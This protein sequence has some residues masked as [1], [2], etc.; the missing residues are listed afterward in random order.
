MQGSSDEEFETDENYKISIPIP[1]LVYD[2]KTLF[3]TQN[4]QVIH[5]LPACRK[6]E[7]AECEELRH[8]EKLCHQIDINNLK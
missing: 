8:N 2:S 1:T 6:K 3:T 7:Y 5:T 4:R